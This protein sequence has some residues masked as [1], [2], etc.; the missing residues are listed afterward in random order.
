M[1]KRTKEEE[2]VY[3]RELR[4]RNLVPPI[5]PPAVNCVPPMSIIVPPCPTQSVPCPTCVDL[6][7]E[8]KKLADEVSLLRL[9]I[10]RGASRETLGK[11]SEGVYIPAAGVS[12]AVFGGSLPKYKPLGNSFKPNALYGA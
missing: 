8:I 4:S 1:K 2:K 12:P 10:K 7:I 5:V 3:K 6:R 9:A 11:I